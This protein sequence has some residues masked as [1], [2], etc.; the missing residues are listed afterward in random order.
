MSTKL[1]RYWIKGQWLDLPPSL[2]K[3]W[4]SSSVWKSV[5]FWL[6]AG[7]PE[8]MSSNIAKAEWQNINLNL[9]HR[10]L[11]PNPDETN[12]LLCRWHQESQKTKRSWNHD[13]FVDQQGKLNTFNPLKTSLSQAY[14]R[15]LDCQ[16][17]MKMDAS[18]RAGICFNFPQTGLYYKHKVRKRQIL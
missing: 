13:H 17:Q 7:N 6:P 9:H 11:K 10:S 3:H 8:E 5:G 4:H 2:D 12:K 14:S 1:E 16:N 18:V 15:W